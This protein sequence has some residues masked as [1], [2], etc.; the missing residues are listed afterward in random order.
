MKTTYTPNLYC[1]LALIIAMQGIV[2]SATAQRA[3]VSKVPVIEKYV[4]GYNDVTKMK[5]INEE[6]LYAEGW[7][8]LPQP[9]FWQQI[10]NLSPD[11][12][13]VSM[14]S[15][16]QMLDRISM[17][18]WGVLSEVQKTIYK[19]SIRRANN[20]P[21]SLTLYITAGKK[22]FYEF[23]KVMP[24]IS[25]SINVFRQNGVDPWYAQAILLIESPGKMNTKSTVGANGPFQLMK[26]V[27]KNMGLVVNAKVD[28]RTDI[29]K[30]ALGASRLLS[31]ICI[32][33][34]RT[35]LDS[36]HL[37]YNETDLWFRLLVLHA[38][39][40]G[41]GNVAGVIRKINP[42]EGGL[43]LIQTVWQT[44]YGGFKNA[45]QNYSQLALAA[46]CNFNKI[47]MEQSDSVYLIE[48]DRM[49]FAY[50]KGICTCDDKC[51][52]LGNC[53]A[54]YESDLIDGLIPFDYFIAK[55]KLVENE[56]AGL[57]PLAYAYGH[58]RYNSIGFKLLK[59]RKAEEAYKVFKHNEISYP[60]SWSVYQGLG[61]SYRLMGQKEQAL[62]NYKK[63]LLLNPDNQESQRAVTRLSAK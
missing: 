52:Y 24:T 38:Y 60:E 30:S 8:N 19:D 12:G 14:A 16:R 56:L 15:T 3:D 43:P 26:A 55:T 31:R 39:H 20:I 9:K 27:A 36:A 23:K 18:N 22:D 63:S 32:P 13:I 4:V 50:E 1:L 17:K 53:I 47:V 29:E 49:L 21:D 2:M 34:V 6:N 46:F 58:E 11:S 48:G 45:S 62:L 10:M 61:E 33:Y 57:A 35:I 42:C 44:S 54:K 25:R 59:A 51:G 40:A 7:H 5:F 41:A 28:E 37:Q